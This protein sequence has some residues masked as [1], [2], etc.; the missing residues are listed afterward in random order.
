[1]LVFIF[2]LWINTS[3]ISMMRD[4]FGDCYI[5]EGGSEANII[6]QNHTCAEVAGTIQDRENGVK[7]SET[8]KGYQTP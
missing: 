8:E 1:M 4:A 2:G 5:W 3:D 6:V 7:P